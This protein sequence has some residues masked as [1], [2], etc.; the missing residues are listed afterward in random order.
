M[1]PQEFFDFTVNA[2][3]AQGAPS[4]RPG[5]DGCYFFICEYRDPHGNKCAAGHHIPDAVYKPEME[6][7]RIADVMAQYPGFADLAPH[8]E[9]LIAL[10]LH[11]DEAA[12]ITR[13]D[14]SFME[15]FERNVSLGAPRFGLVYTPPCA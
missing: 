11:H 10:Q 6:G 14:D 4:G 7:Q 12:A 15:R 3:R 8:V 2:I 9:L 1:T 13:D 5:Q